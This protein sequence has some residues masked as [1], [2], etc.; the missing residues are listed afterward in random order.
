MALRMSCPDVQTISSTLLLNVLEM[1]AGLSLVQVSV[2]NA[3]SGQMVL[4]IP[5]YEERPGVSS[6]ERSMARAPAS[7][8]LDHWIRAPSICRPLP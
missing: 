5:S 8:M 4:Q 2:F 1:P 6:N 3:S 7:Y